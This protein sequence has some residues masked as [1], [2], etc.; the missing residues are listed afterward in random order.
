VQANSDSGGFEV[1]DDF[2]SELAATKGGG[3]PIPTPARGEMENAFGADFGGIRL[4]TDSR[5]ASMSRKINAC[6]FT[7]GTDIYFNEGMFNPSTDVGKH[8]LAHELTHAIQQGEGKIRRLTL[9]P[10]LKDKGNCGARRTRWTFSL[11]SPAP[12]DG[13]I[14]QW[15]RG[16]ETIEACPSNVSSISLTPTVE[17]WE[18][19]D[20][21]KGNTVDWTTTRDN[22][23]DE[24]HRGEGTNQSGCQA[25]LGTVKFFLRSVTGDLGG[26]GVAPAAS[27][28]AWG[29]GKA[30]MS[31]ALPSTLSKPS[32]WDNTPTEGPARRWASS[33][34]NCCGEE[35]KHF[36]RIDSNP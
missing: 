4:H 26:F 2:E 28:S 25:S 32:W 33:W 19:W 35:S 29:P 36:S 3:Q 20:V 9:T 22:W 12:D 10:N 31:G 7:H 16:L 24:S 15:I 23:T 14:V 34:W 18:A 13:Y 1:S 21:T 5:A 30:P 8:L 17:Y 6:A 11:D 27:G